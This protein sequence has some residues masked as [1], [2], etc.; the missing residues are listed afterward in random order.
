MRWGEHTGWDILGKREQR[1]GDFSGSA[2]GMDGARIFMLQPGI[3]SHG[4]CPHI[5]RHF[6]SLDSP[7]NSLT[8][9]SCMCC[10]TQVD[11]P[12]GVS[13]AQLDVR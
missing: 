3:Y 1:E 4:D 11:F 7:L 5:P 13:P 8:D 2:P 9:P 12:R 6:N 10:E